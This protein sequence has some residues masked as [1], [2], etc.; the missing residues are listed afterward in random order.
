MKPLRPE[1]FRD[2]FVAINDYSPFAWQVRLCDDVV[3]N[4]DWPTTIAAPTG[5]GKSHVVDV[6]VFLNALHGWRAGPRVP[7]RLAVVVNRRAIVDSHEL[8]AARILQAVDDPGSPEIIRRVAEGLRRLRHQADSDETPGGLVVA[9]L[10][11]GLAPESG[12]IDD[13]TACAIICATPDMW[14]SRLLFQSYGGS[15][16]ARPREAGL[17]AYDSVMILDEAHLN[18]QLLRTARRVAE[19]AGEGLADVP[20]LQ[21]V[22]TTATPDPDDTVRSDRRRVIEVTPQ[23]VDEEPRLQSRLRNPK[24]LTYYATVTWPG[25]RK[26]S[27]NYLK[28]VADIVIQAVENH[29]RGRTVACVVNNVDRAIKISR[30]LEEEY[31]KEAVLTWVGRMRP[32]DLKRMQH[33]HPDAFT[34]AGDKRIRVLV[35]TQTVEVGIDVDFAA[36]VTELADGSALAQRAGRVNR[37]GALSEGSITVVGPGS[38]P[39]TDFLPYRAAQLEAA[40]EWLQGFIGTPSGLSPSAIRKDPAPSPPFPRPVPF[41]LERGDARLLSATSEDLLEKVDVTRHLRDDLRNDNRSVGV[42]LRGR[43]SQ[44]LPAIDIDALTLLRATPPSAD[45]VYPTRIDIAQD[46]LRI[47][48]SGRHNRRAFV[49]RAGELSQLDLEDESLKLSPGDIVV[50]DHD[51]PIVYRG[52]IVSEDGES[53]DGTIWGGVSDGSPEDDGVTILLTRPDDADLLDRIQLTINQAEDD[54]KQPIEIAQELVAEERRH[55]QVILGPGSDDGDIPWIVL[56][57]TKAMRDIE[58]VRQTWTPGSPVSLR[59]HADQVAKRSRVLATKLDLPEGTCM[60]LEQAGRLHD[61]GKRHPD[62]QKILGNSS[63]SEPLAKSGDQPSQSPRR[64]QARIALPPR[65][66]HEQLS[67]AYASL[68]LTDVDRPHR[69]LV[70]RLVGTS[71]GWGR[72]AFPHSADELLSGNNAS[73]ELTATAVRLFDEGAWETLVE[74]T[75][76]AHGAWGC[77]YLEAVLRAADC[78]VSKEGS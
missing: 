63:R 72:A 29:G 43:A 31:G 18:R 23:D 1:E 2:F 54:E 46:V 51:H 45:E 77:A 64:R 26:A 60:A 57:P 73:E 7:R 13:P 34:I 37:V 27:A 33:D 12:W 14:G 24:P 44:P 76:R 30:I 56:R 55:C 16:L 67:V 6:H 66:R 61:E 21:V 35:A 38:A 10:R 78:Q 8:R 17:L 15:R 32:M 3:T 49:Y 39:T 36:L 19:L 9:K 28:E 70:L 48:H 68:L 52:V 71:H 75:E 59:K 20:A 40:Y 69:D 22:A 62:F 47:V 53:A 65:W 42:V 11:G 5:S 25:S 4:G 41:R 58:E 74:Q 50:L